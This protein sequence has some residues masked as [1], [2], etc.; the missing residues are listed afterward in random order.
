MTIVFQQAWICNLS[1][2]YIDYCG[3]V[4]GR[5]IGNVLLRTVANQVLAPV[6]ISKLLDCKV[7]AKDHKR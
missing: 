6:L 3:S 7:C 1:T 4:P 5:S 2:F